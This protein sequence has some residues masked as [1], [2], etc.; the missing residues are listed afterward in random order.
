MRGTS[1]YWAATMPFFLRDAFG[2]QG[3]ITPFVLPWGQHIKLPMQDC[4]A[5][6]FTCFLFFY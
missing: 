3:H 1:D 6:S 2:G 5:G 4:T